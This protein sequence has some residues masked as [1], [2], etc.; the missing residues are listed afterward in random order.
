MKPAEY[1]L[2]PEN[3]LVVLLNHGDKQAFA[4]L[5][6]RYHHFLIS[7]ADRLTRDKD[8]SNDLIQEVFIRA[9]QHRERLDDSKS[10]FNYLK[11]SVRHAFLN[12]ERSKTSNTA[13]KQELANYLSERHEGVEGHL[14]EKELIE[15]LETI[16]RMLPG[17]MGRVFVMTHFEQ[18]SEAEI[19]AAL[20]V[21]EKT[22]RNLL[23]QAITNIRLRIGLA[24]A[25]GILLS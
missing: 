19:A 1:R 15:R 11:V 14:A 12:R 24:I 16:A 6:H 20:Q 18:Y 10:L 9:W 2:L 21:S 7:F 8:E 5:F 17:K 13:F 22:V 3:R 23:S 4:E 25:L